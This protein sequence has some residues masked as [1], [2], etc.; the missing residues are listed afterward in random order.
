MNLEPTKMAEGGMH[1]D[2]AHSHHAPN[3]V[4]VSY[5]KILKTRDFNWAAAPEVW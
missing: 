4:G 3:M 2:I 5:I 1:H